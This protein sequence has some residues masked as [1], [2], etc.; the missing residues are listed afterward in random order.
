MCEQEAGGRHHCVDLVE[1]VA[2]RM[3]VQSQMLEKQ[4]LNQAIRQ[5]KPVKTYVTEACPRLS[6]EAVMYPTGHEVET[7]YHLSFWCR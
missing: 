3:S 7:F 2:S 1:V 6:S 5:I 4:K